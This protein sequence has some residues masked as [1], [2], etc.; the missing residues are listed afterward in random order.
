VLTGV[1]VIVPAHDEQD[2]LPACLA[3]L[4]VAQAAAG[5]DS[6]VLV[7]LDACSDATGDIAA[8]AGARTVSLSARN[9]GAARRAGVA[10][11]LAAYGTTGYWLAST[12]ADSR[13]PADWLARQLGYARAGAEIVVGT[14]EVDDW[15]GW[16]DT[17]AAR[18][19]D[20][21]HR[22]VGP[23]GH[24]HVHGANLGTTAEAYLAVGGFPARRRAE[25]RAF[26]ARA[27]RA[28]RRIVWATDL[29][30]LTSARPAARVAGGFSGHLHRLA[31][32]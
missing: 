10:A 17:L 16:P 14:V 29:P 11:A 7:V 18:Y 9:V 32:R 2:L 25:D 19:H 27:R 12:D 4:A 26:V 6:T 3:S 15:S 8:A 31:A 28:G 5:I 22:R 30:V 1:A 23:T 13:V 24:N 20:R 21:Y